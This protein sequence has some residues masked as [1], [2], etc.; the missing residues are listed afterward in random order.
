MAGCD[1]EQGAKRGV[2]GTAAGKAEGELDEIGLE[3]LAARA[4][5]DAQSPDRE[6]GG[7][8]GHAR[9]DG[10]GGRG[11]DDTG[12]GVGVARGLAELHGLGTQEKGRITS[13]NFARLFQVEHKQE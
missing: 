9:R 4:V 8:A 11:H 12:R 3:V 1:T 6:V 13:G 7:A 2:A 5:G 10:G